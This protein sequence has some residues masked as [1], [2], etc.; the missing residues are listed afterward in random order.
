MGVELNGTI[1]SDEMNSQR[2]DEELASIISIPQLHTQYR[3]FVRFTALPAHK[4]ILDA[5]QSHT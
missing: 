5:L 3:G 1:K 4:H 2:Q